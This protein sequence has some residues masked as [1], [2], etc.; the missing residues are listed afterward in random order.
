MH[1][2]AV[3]IKEEILFARNV[4]LENSADSYL[5]FWLALL[6][7]VSYLF[8]LCR[9]PSLPLCMVFDSISSN[10]DE[11]LLINQFANVFV[12]GNF[13]VIIRTGLP[14]LVELI[15]LVNSVIF[16]LSQ[17]T[18]LKWLTFLLGSQTVMILLFSI[19]TSYASICSTMAFPSLQNCDPVVVSVSIEFPSNCK[20]D[21]LFHCIAHDYP[22][23]DW[24]G[25]RDHSRDVPWE[26]I[27]KLGVSAAAS[28]PHWNDVET[29]YSPEYR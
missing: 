26:D 9:S 6:H 15:D 14:I 23:A 2:L 1:G 5:C 22:H 24:D 4:S 28:V 19:L 21:P 25:L 13:N 17:M 10:I 8:S 12:F 29:A 18:L 27:C 7:S 20:R 3:Y 11:L 16:F